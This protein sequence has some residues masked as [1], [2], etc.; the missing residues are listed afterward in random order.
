MLLKLYEDNPNPNQIR[1]IAEVIRNGGIVIIPTDTLYAFACDIF[2]N[3]AVEKITKL[4]GKDVRK[5]NL[6]FVC[7]DVAQISEYAKMDDVAFKLIKKNLPGPFTF[8][9]NGSNSLPKL[10]KNKKEVGVRMSSNRIV[11]EI[12]KE[13]GHPLMVSSVFYDEDT[14]Y[15]TNP[16]LIDEK[17]GKQV[18]VVIDG[19]EGTII[20]STIVDC[21]GD[22]PF[23]ARE[24]AGILQD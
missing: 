8:I 3:A 23:V 12:L 14:D 16:E 5:T 4:K 18:D 1:R 2:N 7:H 22:E 15:M 9:L 10:F 19:G 17:I 13:L 20:P 24:G 11:M 6:S 21:T